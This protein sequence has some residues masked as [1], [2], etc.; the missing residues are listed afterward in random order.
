MFLD[1]DGAEVLFDPAG[2]ACVARLLVPGPTVSGEQL[3]A[4]RGRFAV[5]DGLA[6]TAVALEHR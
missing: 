5:R 4:L 1:L 2:R 3:R 6:A